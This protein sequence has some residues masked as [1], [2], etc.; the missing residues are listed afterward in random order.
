MVFLMMIGVPLCTGTGYNILGKF[1][2]QMQKRYAAVR[3]RVRHLSS[4]HRHEERRKLEKMLLYM[5]SNIFIV[6]LAS[7]FAILYTLLM[8]IPQSKCTTT[9]MIVSS[10][11]FPWPSA[12]YHVSK[13]I[14]LAW[15]H[16]C[17]VVFASLSPSQVD[18]ATQV[19]TAERE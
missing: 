15:L 16:W 3:S 10:P 4:A 13:Q 9:I 19:D 17:L 5:H 8:W 2:M 7:L 18:M 11:I 14:A 12:S 6:F 1:G